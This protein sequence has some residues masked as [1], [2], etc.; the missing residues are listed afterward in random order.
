MAIFVGRTLGHGCS[1]HGVV[2]VAVVVAVVVSSRV[3]R[4]QRWREGRDWH[5]RG[6]WTSL[7]LALLLFHWWFAVGEC[8]KARNHQDLS[9]SDKRFVVR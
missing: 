9:K 5:A 7:P 4:G 3:V 2:V 6:Y 8:G 1:L